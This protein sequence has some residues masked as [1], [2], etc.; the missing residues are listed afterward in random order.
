MSYPYEH[1]ESIYNIIP[2][3]EI[4]QEKM[5]MY[6]SSFSPHIPPTGTT[7]GGAQTTH[8]CC[9]NIAG[10]APQKIVPNKTGRTMGKAPGTSSNCPQD[11]MKKQAN[12]PKVKTLSEVKKSAPH[13]LQPSEL[14]PK[15]KPD[16]PK[17]SELPVMNL[18]SSKNFVV[19]NAVETILASPRKVPQ[20][21]K[22]YLQKED[23]GKIPKYLKN[24]KQDINAE[25][26]YIRQ[27]QQ[28]EAEAASSQVRG[29][30]EEE[31]VD[32]ISGLKAKWESVNT[33]YQ[34]TTHLTILDTVGKVIRKEKY[35][36]QLSQIEKDIEKLNRRNIM[37]ARDGY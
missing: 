37:V 2:P 3:K 31:R 1:G 28:Q 26:E 10:T 14:K 18:V 11:Y 15:L 23:F 24:I 30:A 17:K 4:Q 7:F 12:L 29:M 27:L 8:P 9:M 32:L 5:A 34:A 36:A 21:A 33:E 6:R 13:L 20:G 35:E 25:Y 19:A 22:E 16:V